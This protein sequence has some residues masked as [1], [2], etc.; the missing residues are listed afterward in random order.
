MLTRQSRLIG[1][2][3]MALL[4]N[5][6]ALAAGHNR[7]DTRSQNIDAIST[8]AATAKYTNPLPIQIP[9][10]GIV[11]SCADPSIIR[12]QTPYNDWYMYCTT[13]P[14]NDNDQTGGN[15]NFHL[16]PMLRSSDLVNWTYEGDAFSSRPA[17]VAS[18][19]GL[20]APEIKFFNNQYYL[21][22]TASDTSLPGGGSAIGMR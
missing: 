20:W 11:E 4:M 1:I 12:G 19:A 9:G 10:D 18:N 8:R 22:Y 3:V 16:I 2:I 21:Y 6:P 14:L 7:Q 13:D 17:W 5:S 15:F